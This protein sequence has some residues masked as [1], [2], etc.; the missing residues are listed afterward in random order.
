MKGIVFADALPHGW[1][2]TNTDTTSVTVDP[3]LDH[4]SMFLFRRNDGTWGV[5]GL[6]GGLGD[7]SDARGHDEAQQAHAEIV[8]ELDLVSSFKFM[9]VDR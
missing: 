1:G 8:A 7:I 4:V 9:D 3:D 6:I 5:T 2:M